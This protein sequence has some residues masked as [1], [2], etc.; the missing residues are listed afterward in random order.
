[1][2]CTKCGSVART[3]GCKDGPLTT[4]PGCPCPP[5]SNCMVPSKCAEF[6]DSACVFYNDA[7]ILDIGIEQ[8][9]SFQ[10]VIQKLTLLLTNPNC[11]LPGSSCLS[12]FN[13]YPYSIGS[14]SIAIAWAPSPTSVNYQVEYKNVTATLWSV[15]PLQAANSPLTAVI[16]P[17]I[18]GITYLIRVNTFCSSGNC[19]SVTLKITT[20]S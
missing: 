16:S 11:A 3:C 7:S 4:T 1:M 5:D 20:K 13:V 10:E 6:V 2:S 18:P 9:T 15:L 12:T 17:L 14:S 8:G 19:Y